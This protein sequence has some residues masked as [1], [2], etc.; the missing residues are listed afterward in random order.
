[1]F[2]GGMGNVTNE[3]RKRMKIILSD[4]RIGNHI[5]SR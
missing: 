3:I 5:T 4:K 1:M 2:F